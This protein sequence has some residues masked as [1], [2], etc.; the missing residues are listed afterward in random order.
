MEPGKQT[1]RGNENAPGTARAEI[2]TALLG[3]CTSREK[4][5]VSGTAKKEAAQTGAGVALPI[6]ER[7]KAVSHVTH[8][9]TRIHDREVLLQTLNS[10]GMRYAEQCEVSFEGRRFRFDIL[11]ERPRGCCIGFEPDERDGSYRI[12]YCGVNRNASRK[13]QDTLYQLYARNKILKEAGLRN[14]VLAREQRCA[15]N[16]LRLVL[17]KIA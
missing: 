13:F 6:R 12:A 7:G 1:R 8:V 14:Y 2:G 9:Q 16:R 17:R 10:L 11:L 4:E 3:F 15:E 5:E